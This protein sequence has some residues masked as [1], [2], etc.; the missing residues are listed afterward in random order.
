MIVC[1][2][3]RISHRDIERHAAGCDNFDELQ[4]STGVA[5]GCGQCGDCAR[6]MY[7][8]MRHGGACRGPGRDTGLH[9]SLA[10]AAA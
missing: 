10:L 1:I 3:R 2:C 8:D 6:S 5:T 9:E 7:N 4:M